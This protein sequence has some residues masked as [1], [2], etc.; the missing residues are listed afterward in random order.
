[1]RQIFSLPPGTPVLIKIEG[2]Y[3]P[4]AE[5]H[6]L[7]PLEV[8]KLAFSLM[9]K[10]HMKTFESNW[11]VN[12]GVSVSGLGRFRVNVMRQ[13]GEVAMAVRNVKINPPSIE[14]INVPLNL[15]GLVMQKRGL[16]LVAGATGSGK[17]IT[18]AST[19]DH[20]NSTTHG[21]ILTIEDPIEFLHAYKNQWSINGKSARTQKVMARHSKMPCVKRLIPS[22]NGKRWPAV[23]I[24]EDSPFIK[25]LIKKGK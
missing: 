6:R 15:K 20:R 13:R 24:L 25:G 11:E 19:V 7:S 10:P 23:E 4:I 5:H 17:S 8:K 18:F 21:H 16:I 14:E 2:I 9:N 12:M 22:I 1:M 3:Q